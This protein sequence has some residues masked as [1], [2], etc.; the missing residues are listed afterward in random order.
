[1]NVSLPHS[2]ETLYL[3]K[4]TLVFHI[5]K[6]H[7]RP[8]RV[9][10]FYA[11]GNT[12]YEWRG[13]IT[14][15]ETLEYV[16]LS[17]NFCQK[18]STYFFDSAISLKHLKINNNVLG[19]SLQADTEGLSFKNLRNLTLLDIGSYKIQ[20]LPKLIFKNLIS[21]RNLNL[22]NNLMTDFSVKLNQM[23]NL[24]HLDLSIN[25]LTALAPH[26]IED[27]DR[28]SQN[29]EITVDFTGNPLRCECRYIEFICWVVITKVQLKFNKSDFCISKYSQT[30]RVDLKDLKYFIPLLEKHCESYTNVI[31]VSLMLIVIFVT[32]NLCIIIYRYRW[33]LRYLFYM[34]KSQYYGYKQSHTADQNSDFEFDAFISHADEDRHFAF[35]QIMSQLKMKEVF[36]FVFTSV[37]F[38]LGSKLLE[39]SPTPFIQAEK[40]YV[41]FQ[42]TT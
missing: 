4:S 28:I 5:G 12:F 34:T 39:I 18:M 42:T 29:R 7:P 2:L 30:G 25:Q 21:L 11:Q 36:D 17:N 38:N 31:V 6:F 8:N 27:L 14:G 24:S 9:K 19:F 16:D 26:V 33:K 22:R 35:H 37:I 3:N 20:H 10:R 1:M 32:T 40:P 23:G 41:L 15:G 13:P